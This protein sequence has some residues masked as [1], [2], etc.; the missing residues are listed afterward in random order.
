M[1]YITTTP[2]NEN[3]TAQGK[4]RCRSFR[5]ETSASLHRPERS[6]ES[7][8]IAV[9]TRV[10]RS[11]AMKMGKPACSPSCVPATTAT[12]A[13]TKI[14]GWPIQETKRA[15]ARALHGESSTGLADVI[16]R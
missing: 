16:T 6:P 14:K 1:K 5:T 12:D 3:G 4:K 2:A 9:G 15:N 7:S 13:A 10:V 8:R 11:K